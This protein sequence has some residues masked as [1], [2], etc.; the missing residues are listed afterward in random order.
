MPCA[1]N[2]SPPDGTQRPLHPR[3]LR[4]HVALVR[5]RARRHNRPRRGRTRRRRPRRLV[6][7]TR[8]C[9]SARAA[10]SKPAIV[11]GENFHLDGDRGLAKSWRDRARENI[12][13]IRLA[14]AVAAER[15]PPTA[16]EQA[17]LIRFTGFGASELA[18]GVFRRPGE[19]A[20]RKGW[21]E[22]GGEL[23]RV[24]DAR[25]YASLAR[26]TQYAHFTPEYIVRAV[27]TAVM[28]LGFRGGRVLEP[29][30][31]SGLF[32]ALM[33]AALRDF[34]HVTGVEL[35][36]VTAQIVKLLQ[37]HARILNE[38]FAR[39]DLKPHFD[40][41]IGNPPFSDRTVRS[42]HAFRALGLRLHDYFIAK[43]IQSLKPG[44]LAAFVTSCGTMDKAD[45]SARMHIAATADLVGAI[46]LPE[47]SFRTDAGT[48][49]V[50]DILFFRKRLEREYAGSDAWLGLAEV[51]GASE[52][53]GAIRINQ[54]FIE[55]PEMVLG[56]HALAS[57][58]YGEAYTCL[59]RWG[60]DLGET[61]AAAVLRLPECVY[62]G[63]PEAVGP[64]H[65]EPG[66][67]GRGDE[68]RVSIRE[69]SYFIGA[70]GA[71]VQIVDGEAVTIKIRRGRSTDGIFEKHARIVRKLIPIRDAVREILKC[72][73]T[74]QSWKQ[75]QVRLRIAWSSFVRD[76]GPINTT[77]VSSVEDEDTGEI[78]ETHRRPNL[79]PF[80]DDPDC[81]LVASIEDYG[82]ESNTAK[83]GPIFT[84]R[85][86]A[87]PP[88]PA[89]TSAVDA[90]AVVLNERGA[91]DPAHVAELLHGD[92]DAVIAELGDAI[93]RDPENGSWLTA[94]AYLSGA[95]RSKLAAARAAAELDPSFARNVAALERVQPP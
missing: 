56:T 80:A 42:D 27:W 25:S 49:V 37:P 87:P 12:A 77:V 70:N 50:V 52:D 84:E 94:D 78:R 7:D 32:P 57:G 11:R 67:D 54:Y 47:G 29:G 21:E 48:D 20:F 34:C 40:L 26:G 9:P 33:P 90:L 38:D 73:E 46:R 65:P 41:A 59:P 53:E 82:L 72:Q 61:L 63:E 13:A 39:A 91:V 22:V 10:A 23:E 68:R 71:L 79:A 2:R 17:R 89:I 55:H 81:W 14:A 85:V 31:G 69:G 64:G 5:P 1:P 6:Y 66:V 93:L 45:A 19:A 3:S 95:V 16:E 60:T 51:R 88:A 8:P 36:P 75:P 74:D 24:V 44:G 58:P 18:N 28:R 43:S 35:D 92:V 4:R 62:D 30:I 83:P 15:R 86:I 76:F